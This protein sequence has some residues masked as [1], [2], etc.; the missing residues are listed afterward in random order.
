[1]DAWRQTISSSRPSTTGACWTTVG[2]PVRVVSAD[3]EA[4]ERAPDCVCAI[5]VLEVTSKGRTRRKA[6]CMALKCTEPTRLA[7]DYPVTLDNQEEIR[8]P[9]LER[10]GEHAPCRCRCFAR[11]AL[12]YAHWPGKKSSRESSTTSS[13]I[14]SSAR[15]RR[16]YARDCRAR[17][18]SAPSGSS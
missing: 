1:M 2:V 10:Q 5:A 15:R 17:P 4:T 14:T 13:V 9:T 8:H 16:R 6:Q 12:G 11:C 7:M 18:L 3:V